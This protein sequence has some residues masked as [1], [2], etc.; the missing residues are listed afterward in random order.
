MKTQ[1]SRDSFSSDKRYSGVYL[2]QGRMITDADWNEEAEISK[3]RLDDA[4]ADAVGSG[5][6]RERGLGV[7]AVGGQPLRLTRGRVYAGGVGALVTGPSEDPAEPFGLGEQPDFPLPADEAPPE[8]VAYRLYA[9]LWERTVSSL[10]D[11][12]QLRDPAFHGADT[13]TRTQ[14]MAQ[15][16][17]CSDATDPEDPDV[18]PPLGDARLTLTLRRQLAGLD[19]CDP[20]A[21]EVSVP[22]RIGNYLFRLEVHAVEGG[23]RNP[24]RLTLKWSS[25]NGAEQH[26]HAPDVLWLDALPA[27]FRG[28]DWVYE[29]FTTDSEKHL[30]VH[31]AGGITPVAPDL[32]EGFPATSPEE[33]PFVRRWDGYCTLRRQGTAWF[34][35]DGRERGIDLTTGSAVDADGH[36]E[37]TGGANAEA[38]IQLSTL[39][40]D[41]SLSNQTSFVAGDYWLAVVREAV[42]DPGDPVLEEALPV[43]V[44]HHY[45]LLAVVD[46]TGALVAPDTDRQQLLDFPSLT[47]LAARDVDYTP[48]C[49]SGLFD[50]Q[51]GD[52]V[53]TVQK[54][55]D[56]VCSIDASHVGF[57]K[58]CDTS[59]FQGVD[60]ATINTVAKAL[61]L[62]C[63]VRADQISYR[64]QAGCTVLSG[65]TTVQEALHLLCLN[66]GSGGGCRTTVG[67]GGEYPTLQEAVAGLLNE[68]ETDLCFCL[69]PGDHAVD[70]PLVL[71][72]DFEQSLHFSL[73]GCGPATRL[74]LVQGGFSF[75]R[76]ASV[77][78]ENFTM[79]LDEESTVKVNGG[80]EVIVQGC[81]VIIPDHQAAAPLFLAAARVVNLTG[82][83][84]RALNSDRLALGGAVFRPEPQLSALF[85]PRAAFD[86]RSL[87]AGIR[88]ASSAVAALTAA[89]RRELG[90]AI[91]RALAEV[92]AQESRGERLQPADEVAFQRVID[93]LPTNART[94]P[95]RLAE[96]LTDLHEVL[97]SDEAVVAVVIN[98]EGGDAVLVDNR[99]VGQV[100]IYGEPGDIL[101]DG[102]LGRIRNQIG[103]GRIRFLAGEECLFL[104]RNRMSRLR[105]ADNVN[106][107]LREVATPGGDVGGIF[108]TGRLTDNVFTLGANEVVCVEAN[109]TN[110]RFVA[111]EQGDGVESR[112]ASVVGQEAFY[113]GNH[114]PSGFVQDVTGRFNVQTAGDLNTAFI[115]DVH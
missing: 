90:S 107:Q 105:V 30:G 19:P 74:R 9:D 112:L 114:G 16:K 39:I 56:R 47:T 8:G 2:Q 46:D 83:E 10:E 70:G 94:L 69:L 14:T 43:G 1:V 88:E 13:A 85:Q 42:H 100:S 12:A 6:P 59:I 87:V 48:Q 97:L 66:S 84:I 93:L 36:I 27:D 41:L 28:S 60:P 67:D 76:I 57:E 44:R 22:P 110:N 68:G 11:P 26:T 54:A 95:A 50:A 115:H 102:E 73:E 98:F 111:A 37:L 86:Q 45:L 33:I 7:E 17:W 20:C 15:L 101:V 3:R 49:P 62:L 113:V 38:S 40:L 31:L 58:T 108:R 75:D 18:N 5:V 35:V 34:L 64:N 78:L 109:L 80:E 79:S 96:A 71:T 89:R 72:G 91:G 29:F 52:V 23:P 51:P 104:A 81:T 24:T 25:E 32:L 92:R 4:F 82:N 103:A 106:D 63:D 61:A 77:R 65:A 99:I 53:D 21:A 55:L